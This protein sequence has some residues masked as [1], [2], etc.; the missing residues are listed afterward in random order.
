MKPLLTTTWVKE[1]N[2]MGRVTVK[3]LVSN[4]QKVQL[5]ETGA[6]PKEQVAHFELDAVADSGSTSLILPQ[7]VV[8]RLGFPPLGETIVGYGDGRRERRATVDQVRVDVLGRHGT[9]Q[10]VVEP[11][12][13]TALL[14]AI[15]METLDLVVDCGQERVFPRDPNIVITDRG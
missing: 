9:F 4:N 15:V 5:A 6:L 2:G 13:T 1:R 14:G 12:R 10:A 8:D 7:D 3:I 11:N